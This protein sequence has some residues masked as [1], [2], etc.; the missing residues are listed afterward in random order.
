M[1]KPLRSGGL[2]LLLAGS[3]GS[4]AAGPAL[5]YQTG[6]LPVLGGQAT[7]DTGKTLRYLDAAGARQVI[8][9]QWGNPP[10]SAEDVQG[11]IV[12]AGLEPG[13]E[14]GWAIVLTEARDGHVADDDAASLNYAQLMKD[15]QAG[16]EENNAARQEAGYEPVHLIGWAETPRYDPA[17]HKIYWAKELAFGEGAAAGDH[18]L[19]YAV[20]V[21]GRD[22]VMELNAVAGMSQLPQ[23]KR[24]MQAVLEQVTF[25]AGHRYE[26]YRA[27]SDKTAAYGVAGLLGVAAAKKAGL[28]AGGLLFLKKGWVLL[29]AALGGLG[30]LFK[31][32][33]A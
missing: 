12:P 22:N 3:A 6:R 26:D 10:E 30:R 21:L 31:R 1:M 4:S 23:V 5:H 33:D 19:N 29:L 11:L 17:A 28:L 24:D 16:T 27:G 32:R 9:D 20:R 14:E 15:M 13:T 18:T 8:V 2:A 7:L 25:N